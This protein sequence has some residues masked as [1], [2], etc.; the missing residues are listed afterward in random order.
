MEQI[1]ITY[2]NQTEWLTSNQGHGNLHQTAKKK[3]TIR[4]KTQTLTTQ[5]IRTGKLTPHNTIPLLI[6]EITYPTNSR[7]DPHNAQPTVKAT[8]DGMVDAKLIPDDNSQIIPQI[9][10][11]RSKNKAPKGTHQITYKFINQEIPF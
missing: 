5:A 9:M 4:Q 2:N 11:Q 10:F 8:I 3:K 7:A 1:T 6:C